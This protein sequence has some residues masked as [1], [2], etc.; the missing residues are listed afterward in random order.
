[1]SRHLFGEC[2]LL[3][4]EN[5]SSRSRLIHFNEIP[6]ISTVANRMI[7]RLF[8]AIGSEN[9]EELLKESQSGSEGQT[10]I[11]KRIGMFRQ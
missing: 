2:I 3:A 7:V 4:I 1:M 8:L 6:I 9:A 5:H 11:Q 10:R